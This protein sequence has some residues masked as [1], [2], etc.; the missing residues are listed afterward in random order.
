MHKDARQ[1]S[2]NIYDIIRRTASNQIHN[3]SFYKFDGLMVLYDTT[4]SESYELVKTWM[5][6]TS[7]HLEPFHTTKASSWL[8]L[9]TQSS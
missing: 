3:D 1:V 4:N 5:P 2:V 6:V 9:S 7:S 8:I